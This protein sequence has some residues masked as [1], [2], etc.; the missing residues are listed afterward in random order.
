MAG[1]NKGVVG[2][3][4]F[5][6][7]R[8]STALGCEVAKRRV[9]YYPA[10]VGPDGKTINAHCTVRAIVNVNNKKLPQNY[11]FVG[12]GKL[13]DFMAT[14]MSPG[15]EFSCSA[16]PESYLARVYDETRKP[17]LRS[18]GQE[19]LVE[20]HSF[21]IERDTLRI[22]AESQKVIDAEILSA[23]RPPNWNDNGPG[24]EAFLAMQKAKNAVYDGI[25]NTFGY[26]KVVKRAGAPVAAAA[27]PSGQQP[28]LAAQVA[29]V[30]Q[31]MQG[32]MQTANAGAGSDPNNAPW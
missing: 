1:L 22:T 9:T 5:T 28:A 3:V 30:L 29:A 2:S 16:K 18:N 21:V 6:G 10:Y 17:I 23:E 4:P 7:A 8:C 11:T 25:S 12:W 19:L 27:A 13:A 15:I 32:N 26:A 31:S 20:R 24:R 14:R